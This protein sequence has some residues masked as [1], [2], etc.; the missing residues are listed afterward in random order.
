M[1]LRASTGADVPSGTIAYFRGMVSAPL[2][3]GR[4]LLVG[5]RALKDRQI[6]PFFGFSGALHA[7]ICRPLPPFLPDA[8]GL[9]GEIAKKF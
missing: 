1:V 6:P 2:D 5:L 7:G 4:S 9:G 3:M 8:R